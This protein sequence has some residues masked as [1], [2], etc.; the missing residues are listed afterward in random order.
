MDPLGFGLENYDALGRWRTLDG[1]LTIDATG[2]LPNGKTFSTPAELKEILK[3][4]P[5]PFVRSLV[6]KLLVFALGRGLENYD[7]NAVDQITRNTAVGG[8]RFSTLMEEIVNSAPFQM[9][10]AAET[11]KTA[12]AAK[13]QEATKN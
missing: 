11:I 6:Q 8:Y 4:D 13:N 9:R 2:I 12:E 1:K 7:R 10:T 3:S 5:D